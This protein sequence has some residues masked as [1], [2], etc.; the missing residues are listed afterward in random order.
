MKRI[1]L[2]SNSL[3]RL[4]RGSLTKT[5]SEYCDEKIYFFKACCKDCGRVADIH[6]EVKQ[7]AESE[8]RKQAK[9]KKNKVG[10]WICPECQPLNG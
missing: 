9:W 10:S 4:T 2:P 5:Y 8:L 3:R 6:Y 1:I 7:R